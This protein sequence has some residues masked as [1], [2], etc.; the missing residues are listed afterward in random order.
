MNHDH[1]RAA[2]AH[3]PEEPLRPAPAPGRSRCGRSG[4]PRPCGGTPGPRRCSQPSSG[5]IVKTTPN[6]RIQPG[7]TSPRNRNPRPSETTIGRNVGPG[8]WTPGGGPAGRR[9]TSVGCVVGDVVVV[10]ERLV[11]PEEQGEDEGDDPD[12]DPGPPNTSPRSRRNIPIAREDRG[13]G[14]AGHVDARR[15]DRRAARLADRRSARSSRTSRPS[16]R[17]SGRRGRRHEDR[18][19][20]DQRRPSPG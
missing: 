13:V 2:E 14:R 18:E 16:G 6:S 3:R 8:T 17:R 5:T 20:R 12:E 4:R 19:Q 1:R 11:A 7:K 10:L 15:R 9:G